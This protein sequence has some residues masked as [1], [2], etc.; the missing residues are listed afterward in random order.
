L[1]NVAY[2]AAGSGA[3][4]QELARELNVTD[5]ATSLVEQMRELAQV[6]GA[7]EF[8][9]GPVLTFDDATQ[10][11]TGESASQGNALL[12]RK[13]RQGFEVREVEPQTSA[14]G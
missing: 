8:R 4:A 2:R 5:D 12:R 13:D 14:A 1:A 3:A 7:G 11:F 9:I 6:H 10:Q